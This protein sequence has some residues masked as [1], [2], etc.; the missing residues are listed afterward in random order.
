M[1]RSKLSLIETYLGIAD[2]RL[3]HEE[4]KAYGKGFKEYKALAVQILPSIK[5]SLL[6]ILV[7][8]LSHALDIFHLG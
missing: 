7:L 5:A 6:Q 8:V 3:R 4:W 2:T 1:L